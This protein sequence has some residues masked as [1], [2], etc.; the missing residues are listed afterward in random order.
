MLTSHSLRTEF[1]ISELIV[2]NSPVTRKQCGK[3]EGKME[4]S[5]FSAKKGNSTPNL[6]L[7]VGSYSFSLCIN[8][9]SKPQRINSGE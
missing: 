2:E 9:A 7:P 1:F 4:C 5:L 6:L 8:F 3:L